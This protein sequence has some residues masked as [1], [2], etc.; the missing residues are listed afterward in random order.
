[1]LYDQKNFDTLEGKKC[2]A[3]HTNKWGSKGYHNA[4]VCNIVEQE[5]NVNELQVRVLF[6]NPT[7][8][9][10]LPCPYYFETDCKFSEDKCKYS[11][12][13]IV[14]LSDLKDYVVPDFESL[15]I[16]SE[17]LAKQKNMLWGRAR[18]KKICE[19]TCEVKFEC[20]KGEVELP[21]DEI[22]PMVGDDQIIPDDGSTHSSD[23]EVDIQEVVNISLLNVPS[24][25]PFG[26][27]EKFTRGIGS[28]LMQKMGYI[29][30]TGLGKLS[31][32]RIDP[33]S[34]VILPAGKSLDHCMNLREKCGGD[35]NLFSAEKI[36]E[37]RQKRQEIR[38]QKFYEREQNKR[39]VFKFLNDT[40]T[41]S[42]QQGNSPHLKSEQRRK[43]KNESSRNLNVASLKTDE[44]IRR[45]ER[46]LYV[47]RES[48]TR[49]RDIHSPMHKS[50]VERLRLTEQE[51][52]SL[53]NQAQNI[54]NEQ[55]LRI[56]KKK[57][58]IF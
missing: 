49:H 11:H 22:F 27:W 33:V 58:T 39:D 19:R 55:N 2:Q 52:S 9:E 12:G 56:D 37:K 5:G 4:M 26:G 46:N 24:N 47:I 10:M 6:T 3:P 41:S 34:A 20:A 45:T 16:G 18:I 30:G 21:F 17:I 29:T 25:G 57:M 48:L 38:N 23:D 8:E 36:L 44:D 28:K 31:D 50:L 54:K 51:L 42:G 14:K 40:L 35:K 13:E 15:K 53:K 43:I 7:H 1:M 32:G